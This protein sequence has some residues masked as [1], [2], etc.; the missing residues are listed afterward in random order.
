M[1][2]VQSQVQLESYLCLCG[3][4]GASVSGVNEELMSVVSLYSLCPC[5]IF[6]T[7][8]LL[9]LMSVVSLCS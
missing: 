7:C 2:L 3:T 6:F 9:E 1:K 8:V 4:C 5:D